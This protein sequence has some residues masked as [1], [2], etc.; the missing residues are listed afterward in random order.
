VAS[1]LK[2][3]RNFIL[4]SD[5]HFRLLCFLTSSGAN[6]VSKVSWFYSKCRRHVSECSI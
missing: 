3:K 5:T 6:L 4:F 1:I 2:K